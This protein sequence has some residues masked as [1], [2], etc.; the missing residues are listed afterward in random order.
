MFNQLNMKK[1]SE[2]LDSAIAYLMRPVDASSL[3]ALRIFFGILMVWSTLKYF[4]NG[5]IKEYYIDP[6]FLFTYELFPWV[7]PWPGD[8]MYYHF[9][10]MALAAFFL[11][12]GFFYR[13]SAIV[14]FLTYAHGFLIEKSL[15]NNHYYFICLIGLLFCVTNAHRWMSL[16][17]LWIKKLQSDAQAGTVP[18]W[19]VLLIKAQVFIVYFYGGIAKLNEDWLRG[20]PLRHWLPGSANNESVPAL[21]AQF[22]KSE[23]AAYFFSYTGLI[24]DLAI[25]FI[26]TLPLALAYFF[27]LARKRGRPLLTSYAPL[28]PALCSAIAL[29]FVF[30][31]VKGLS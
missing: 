10:V 31:T 21:A 2:Y 27:W 17:A 25:G 19:H 4:Y 28:A 29:M 1:S 20:E 22:M 30:R 3:G 12:L 8:G 24:F 15:Y 13:A 26:V 14:F 9:A 23:F 18:Y 11:A 16:D 5:W 6:K 7:S